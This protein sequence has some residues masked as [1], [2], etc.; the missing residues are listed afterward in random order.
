MI[1]PLQW[2]VFVYSQHYQT[3]IKV[4]EWAWTIPWQFVVWNVQVGDSSVVGQWNKKGIKSSIKLIMV[5]LG[6]H[7]GFPSTCLGII[8]TFMFPNNHLF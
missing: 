6:I 4:M 2:K 1:Q 8:Q 3:N 5:I 7:R